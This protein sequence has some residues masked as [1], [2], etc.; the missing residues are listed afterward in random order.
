VT[1]DGL[2]TNTA[3]FVKESNKLGINY[4]PGYYQIPTSF[5]RM[6]NSYP[7]RQVQLALKAIF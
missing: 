7:P 6:T 5:L 1:E 3:Y 4:F 2:Q